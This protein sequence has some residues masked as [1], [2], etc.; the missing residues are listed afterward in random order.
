[1]YTLLLLLLLL[2]WSRSSDVLVLAERTTSRLAIDGGKRRGG[3]RHDEQRHT[4]ARWA[5]A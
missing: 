2:R 4:K 5:D 3:W 1:M